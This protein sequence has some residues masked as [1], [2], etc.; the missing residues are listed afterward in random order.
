MKGLQASGTPMNKEVT[1][2]DAVIGRVGL[3]SASTKVADFLFDNF[4]FEDPA[5][6]SK[7]A[8]PSTDTSSSTKA[9]PDSLPGAEKM[10]YRDG[11][12]AMDLFVFKPEGWKAEDKRSAFVFFSAEAGPKALR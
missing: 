9:T 2:G 5:G 11:D 6:E 4:H 1:A 7:P 8:A 3:S 12:N 10:S